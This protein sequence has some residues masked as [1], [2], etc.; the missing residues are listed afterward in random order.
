[1]QINLDQHMVNLNS[2]EKVRDD[3]KA[4]KFYW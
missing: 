4:V 1:M 2:Q 3:H